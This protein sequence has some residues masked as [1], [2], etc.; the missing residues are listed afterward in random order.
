[1]HLHLYLLFIIGTTEE[2]YSDQHSDKCYDLLF[3]RNASV[4]I[5]KYAYN[6]MQQTVS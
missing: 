4:F 6:C 1:M 5:Y 3:Q 2:R